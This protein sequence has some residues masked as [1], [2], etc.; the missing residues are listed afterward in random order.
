MH[1]GT[2]WPK[3]YCNS[4]FWPVSPSFQTQAD[5]LTYMKLNYTMTNL[6][7]TSSIWW[8]TSFFKCSFRQGTL[9]PDTRNLLYLV[10][11]SQGASFP[12]VCSSW[13]QNLHNYSFP[14]SLISW[15]TL[16]K[17]KKP[18]YE[19]WLMWQCGLEP[20]NGLNMTTGSKRCLK[21]QTET[22]EKIQNL[23]QP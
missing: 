21:K 20:T 5:L 12:A 22:K 13:A 8:W 7:P 17:W 11:T 15:F 4:L 6:F 9:K 16:I 1:S 18:S 3:R 23:Q 10:G 2:Q 14:S 19:F